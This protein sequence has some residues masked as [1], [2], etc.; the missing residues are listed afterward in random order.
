M[1]DLIRS[2]SLQ[3]IEIKDWR[4]SVFL[5]D[6]IQSLST[7]KLDAIPI[8]QDFLFKEQSTTFKKNS[9]QARTFTWACT[10]KKI[11]LAR[12]VAFF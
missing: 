7:F 12:Q 11:K 6:A 1:G 9:L 5:N 8:A 3:A 10:E 2:D 4:W